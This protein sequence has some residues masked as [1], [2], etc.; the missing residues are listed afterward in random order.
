MPKSRSSAAIRFKARLLRPEA[1]PK[2]ETWSFVL[3]PKE[4]SAQLP[5]RAM[6]TVE[7]TLNGHA[8]R[9]M[10]DP[11]GQGSHWLKISKQLRE[12]A[13]AQVGHTV[14]LQITPGAEDLEPEMPAELRKALAATPKAD[15]AWAGLKPSQRRDW[16]H[17][18]TSAKQAETRTRR[19]A[20][21]CDM[22]ATGKRRVCCF[23][24]SGMY[25]KSLSAPKAADQPAKG[26]GRDDA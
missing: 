21:A 24:R 10:L 17:W 13:G 5:T 20:N 25:S 22:L 14:T 7:G 26:P 4:A 2:G 9:A 23:D 15:A 11:D 19:I 8:F 6:T 12:A 3:V 1:P 16:V 18:I